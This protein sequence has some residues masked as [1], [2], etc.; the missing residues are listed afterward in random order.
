MDKLLINF[1]FTKRCP[2]GGLLGGG[3][4][5]QAV[6]LQGAGSGDGFFQS[7]RSGLLNGGGVGTGQDQ[8]ILAAGVVF[9]YSK[10]RPHQGSFF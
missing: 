1:T 2:G 10:P 6:C 7:R 4:G 9:S 8:H 3:S 5:G